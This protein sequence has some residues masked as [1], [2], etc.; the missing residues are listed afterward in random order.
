MH[1]I[2]ENYNSHYIS[3]HY[4][5]D[6]DNVVMIK[7]GW[8]VA[9][10]NEGEDMLL[11]EMRDFISGNDMSMEE[12]YR[13]ACEYIDIDSFI[14][15]YAAQIYIARNNDWPNSNWAAWRTREEDDSVYGDC[16]WRW[17]LFDVNSGGLNVN[18]TEVDTFSEVMGKDSVFSSLYSNEEFRAQFAERILYIGREIFSQKKCDAFLEDYVRVMGQPIAASNMRFYN[19]MKLEAFY[20]NVKNTRT[21]FDKRYETVWNFLVSH[22]GEEWLVEHGIQK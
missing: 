7:N 8:E 17:M 18:L 16:R 11:Y 2:T 12:N 6:E 19:D 5:V 4:H 1:Y 22:M 15:Y 13:K 10:G 21:F 20:E 9:E 3:D 14:D